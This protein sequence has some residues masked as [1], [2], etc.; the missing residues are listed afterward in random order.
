MDG[1]EVVTSGPALE[2]LSNEPLMLAHG[3]EKPHSLQHRHP[4]Q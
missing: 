3:L 1:G 4:H 2:I